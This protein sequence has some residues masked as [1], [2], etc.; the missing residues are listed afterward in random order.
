MNL[1]ET[2][3]NSDIQEISKA[4]TD[5]Y[6][7]PNIRTYNTLLKA[8]KQLKN[9]EKCMEVIRNMKK[10]GIQPDSVTINT[11]VDAAVSSGNLYIAEDVSLLSDIISDFYLDLKLVSPSLHACCLLLLIKRLMAGS[12]RFES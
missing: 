5:Q 10:Q 12:S 8:L 4:F 1:S 3:I 2:Y 7:R 11:L 9:F 6:L